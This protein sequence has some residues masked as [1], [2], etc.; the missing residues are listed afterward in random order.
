[1]GGCSIVVILLVLPG[2]RHRLPYGRGSVAL[3]RNRAASVALYS[4]RPFLPID[5]RG[6][7]SASLVFHTRHRARLFCRQNG[8][9]AEAIPP[10]LGLR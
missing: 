2:L 3:D 10:R 5:M 4:P 1:V 8:A 7:S 9:H 6:P